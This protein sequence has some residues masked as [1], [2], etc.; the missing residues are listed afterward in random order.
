MA[1][2][3]N[4]STNLNFEDRTALIWYRFSG[5]TGIE[6]VEITPSVANIYLG[7]ELQYHVIVTYKNGVIADLT[8]EALWSTSSSPSIADFSTETPGLLTSTATGTCAI[9]VGVPNLFG[10]FEFANESLTIH[11][12]LI[13]EQA[14]DLVDQYRPVVDD[15][16]KLF[17]S[18][19]Q[20]S[21]KLLAWARSFMDIVDDIKDLA[22]NLSFYFSLFRVIDKDAAAYVVNALT[23]KEGDYTFAAMDACVGDQLDILGVILGVPRQVTFDPTDGSSPILD[24][25]TYRILLKN[26]VLKNHWDGRAESL[27]TT[28]KE[29]FPGGTIIIQDNQNMTI[30]VTITGTF[31]QIIIDLIEN[32]YIVPRPQG[33]W[34]NYYVGTISPANLPFF[35]FDRRDTYVSGFDEGHWV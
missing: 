33:V 18:Q 14:H 28:W 22:Q 24:D 6:S 29:L 23:V 19:Y 26:Q 21:T 31:T 17:T 30:D 10:F 5:L 7:D 13:V 20:N 2:E 3:Y 16:I 1:V 25:S 35:G 32:D 8:D 34:M 27:Q 4:D 11:N 12:P 15:Y 9:V